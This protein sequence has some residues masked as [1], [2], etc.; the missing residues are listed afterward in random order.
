M[1][2]T[3]EFEKDSTE[4]SPNFIF[5][6]NHSTFFQSMPETDTIAL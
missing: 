2:M 1:C 4:D 6:N 5:Q 3:P